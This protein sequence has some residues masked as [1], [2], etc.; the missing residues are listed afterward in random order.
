MNI[1]EELLPYEKEYSS[2]CSKIKYFCF[3]LSEIKLQIE[4]LEKICKKELEIYEKQSSPILFLLNN[5]Q[6]SALINN[7]LEPSNLV[8][9]ISDL[10]TVIV[11]NYQY[12]RIG[13]NKCYKTFKDNIPIISKSLEKFRE[14]LFTKALFI[15][16]GNENKLKN[17]EN[18]NKYMN[19]TF[20][21]VLI[22]IFKGLIYIHQFFFLYSQSKNDF[23]NNIKN[24]I[25]NK[26]YN[27]IINIEINDFSERKYAKGEG[28]YY[29][30]IHFGNCNNDIALK[31]ESENIISLCD[32][33]L[34]Y[35]QTF[36]KCIEIR[37]S[38]ISQFKKLIADMVA[39]SPNN[40]IEKIMHIK[41]KIVKTKNNFKI[42]GIDSK[43]LGFAHSKLDIF[44]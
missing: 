15:L 36:I 32:S 14:D 25:D 43:I 10:I 27:K 19:E 5:F 44:I 31:N 6:T 41:D 20:E 7:Q 12:L 16:K 2:E 8:K 29:E 26:S 22:N 39:K 40:I 28:I 3:A 21:L 42:L 23:H 34:Y 11:I 9:I 35:V 18:L 33:Y 17:N 4:F 37:N 1:N 24:D 38:V 13:L 30:P